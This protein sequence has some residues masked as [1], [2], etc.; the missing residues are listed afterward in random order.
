MFDMLKQGMAAAV[1]VM[2][3]YGVLPLQSQA[4]GGAMTIVDQLAVLIREHSAAGDAALAFA[5]AAE[6]DAS[7]AVL[8]VPVSIGL[9]A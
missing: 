9:S 6:A 5:R 1:L 3:P 7:A 4:H 2:L 8:P